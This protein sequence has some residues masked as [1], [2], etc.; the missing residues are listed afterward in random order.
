MARLTVLAPLTAVLEKPTSSAAKA[1][2][3]NPH[4]D[5]SQSVIVF[6]RGPMLCPRILPCQECLAW[7]SAP[8]GPAARPAPADSRTPVARDR[9]GVRRKACRRGAVVPHRVRE[10]GEMDGGDGFGPAVPEEAESVSYRG[11]VDAPPASRRLTRDV[12]STAVAHGRGEHPPLA[13][14][15][16]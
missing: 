6:M 16:V 13:S 1:S 11:C 4:R 10:G 9:V 12:P 8:R 15:N 14:L 7:W 2:A 5:M 3:A